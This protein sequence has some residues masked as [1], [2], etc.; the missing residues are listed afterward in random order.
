ML[1]FQ[2]V[3]A[4]AQQPPGLAEAVV[5]RVV[6]VV[7]AV[8]RRGTVLLI[9]HERLGLGDGLAG[10]PPFVVIDKA[11]FDHA[12]QVGGV[13][14]LETVAAGVVAGARVV[15]MMTSAGETSLAPTV[16]NT[17]TLT[18]TPG[19][20]YG[21]LTSP[22]VGLVKE[23]LATSP[24][25][26]STSVATP[27]VGVVLEAVSVAPTPVNMNVFQPSPL[28]GILYG[29]AAFDLAPEGLLAGNSGVLTVTGIGLN[30]VTSA[31]VNPATGITIGAIQASPDG[32]QLTIP[33]DVAANASV[34]DRWVVLNR[35]GGVVN[36]GNPSANNFW[37]ATAL[38]AFDSVTPNVGKQGTTLTTFTI[39]GT[40][41][42]NTTAILAEPADGI[43]FGVP[44]VDATGTVITVGMVVD[45]TAPV[46]A[47]V[48]RAS[49][50][51][52]LSSGVAVPA[53]TFTVYP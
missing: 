40:N 14:G 44:S 25:A 39:R 37:I 50:H 18:S 7:H 34:G 30:A 11:L 31:T 38:P 1:R 26:V 47:R 27:I 20:E 23:I 13:H 16:A 6:L 8:D 3:A 46:T 32:T 45:V 35:T 43:I 24:P 42:Q 36:F 52:V 19:S 28:V 4:V 53:N 21:P 9:P 29:S 33:V 15:S 12:G 51:G 41:L 48:I 2:I 5:H 10:E 49:T 17:V 22:I